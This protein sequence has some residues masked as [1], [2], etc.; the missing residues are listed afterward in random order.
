MKSLKSYLVAVAS[1]LLL[2][3]ACMKEEGGIGYLE[4][5]NETGM[6]CTVRIY[7]GIGK[8][9]LF[10]LEIP[11]GETGCYFGEVYYMGS[12]ILGRYGNA[13]IEFSDGSSIEYTKSG[14]GVTFDGQVGN[15]LFE[16]NYTAREVDGKY[17]LL[18]KITEQMHEAAMKP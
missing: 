4:Y 16:S 14:G 15:L 2:A 17:H 13:S 9:E 1:I 18:T 6:A 5:K 12:C 3:C 7:G 10:R 11:A 8:P